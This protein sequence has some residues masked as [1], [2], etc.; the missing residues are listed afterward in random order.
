MSSL[1][2]QNIQGSASSSN[3]INVASGH[4]ILGAAGSIIAPGQVIQVISNHYTA[5]ESTS[6]T[7]LVASAV[8]AN[9]TPKFATSKILVDMRIQGILVAANTSCI[10][11]ALYNG[12]EG[13]SYSSLITWNQ[14]SGYTTASDERVYDGIATFQYFHDVNNTNNNR[15]TVYFK[16][17]GSGTI[18]YNNYRS[19]ANTTASSITLTEIAQ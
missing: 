5:I 6:S 13:G 16:V 3:T 12:T 1:T 9:I 2:V 7:S 17:S 19:G 14:A 18:Y 10:E 11:L 15:Y 4:K 8:L